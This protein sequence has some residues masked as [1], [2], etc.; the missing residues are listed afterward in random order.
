MD[1]ICIHWKYLLFTGCSCSFLRS[2]ISVLSNVI[3][4]VLHPLFT[5][6]GGRYFN[7]RLAYKQISQACSSE[8]GT[9]HHGITTLNVSAW[10]EFGSF[11]TGHW[12]LVGHETVI[13]SALIADFEQDQI[14]WLQ[15]LTKSNIQAMK[16]FAV[17]ELKL[18]FSSQLGYFKPRF[19][20]RGVSLSRN[21]LIHW[22]INKNGV[23]LFHTTQ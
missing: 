7:R 9:E 8:H 5:F 23:T 19:F 16:Y 6:T 14:L 13:L 1:G 15:S 4:Y 18:K 3:T 10:A 21:T 17:I 2:V 22:L 12:S 20:E 11:P